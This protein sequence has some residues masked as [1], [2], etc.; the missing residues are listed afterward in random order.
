[1]FIYFVMVYF[2]FF[3]LDLNGKLLFECKI[4]SDLDN[5]INLLFYIYLDGGLE[6]LENV[7]IVVMIGW[8]DI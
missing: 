8:Y 6:W 5:L 3:M 4:V 1:M 2:V 7:D